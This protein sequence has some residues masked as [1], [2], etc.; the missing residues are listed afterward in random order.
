MWRVEGRTE[1]LGGVDCRDWKVEGRKEEV[2]GV[3]DLESRKE[4]LRGCWCGDW[5]EGVGDVESGREEGR[6]WWMWRVE[7]RR[8]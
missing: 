1:G 3:G 2:E 5:K 6:S 4:K 8:W 7:G